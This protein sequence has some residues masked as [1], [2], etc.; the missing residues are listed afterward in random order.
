MH[1]SSDDQHQAVAPSFHVGSQVRIIQG[2]DRGRTG[3][4]T[5]VYLRHARPYRVQLGE[6]W[7]VHFAADSSHARRRC[8]DSGKR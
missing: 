3:R 1:A 8:A 5:A 4:I 6:G 2:P 7:Y